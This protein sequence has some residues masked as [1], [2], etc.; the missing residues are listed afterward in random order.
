M[1]DKA[2]DPPKRIHTITWEDPEISSRQTGSISGIDYLR[3]V[4]DGRIQAP[5]IAKLVGYQIVDIDIGRAVFKLKPAEYHYN[6]F[7][8]VHGGMASTILDT[9][10][11]AAVLSTLPAARGCSTLEIKVNFIRPITASTGELHCRAKTI[12]VGSRIATAEGKLEDN[13]GKLYGHAV[14]TCMIFPTSK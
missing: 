7:A 6:P 9:A 13:R 14:S 2:N 1:S 5:P 8:T 12:H 4:R 3:A 10:M 11:T